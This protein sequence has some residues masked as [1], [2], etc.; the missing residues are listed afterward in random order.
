MFDGALSP[1]HIILVLAAALI[2][3]GPKRLPDIGKSLGK[4]IKEFKGAL[5]HM[6][7]DDD[8]APAPAATVVTTPIVTPVHPAHVVETPVTPPPVIIDKPQA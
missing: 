8:A 1:F 5:T 6:G 7:D 2:I 3:F 4:G